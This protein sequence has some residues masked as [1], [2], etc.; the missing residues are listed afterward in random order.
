MRPATARSE[1]VRVGEL[2]IVVERRRAARSPGP[3]T[4]GAET[5]GPAASGKSASVRW[6]TCA[7]STGATFDEPPQR[8]GI[9]N[10]DAVDSDAVDL[11]CAT[12]ML[13]A[14]S[15]TKKKPNLKFSKRANALEQAAQ[16]RCSTQ[17][18]PARFNTQI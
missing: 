8:H 17:N 9:A 12:A 4:G 5:G 14:G 10:R 18:D 7:S 11:R 6:W 13:F 1:A 2:G 16:L 15:A 3:S